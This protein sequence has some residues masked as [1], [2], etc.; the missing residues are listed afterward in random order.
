MAKTSVEIGQSFHKT[1]YSYY[2]VIW[3]LDSYVENT[4]PVHVRLVKAEEPTTNIILSI[5]VLR[6]PRYFQRSVAAV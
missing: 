6:D 4:E 2:R 1:D 3:T 5:D